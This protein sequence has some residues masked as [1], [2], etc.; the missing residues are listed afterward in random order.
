[1]DDVLGFAG[2]SAVVTGAASGMG[3]ATAQ[4]LLD[5]GANVTALDIKPTDVAVARS[6]EVDLRDPAAIESAAA[7]I[8]G[9]VDA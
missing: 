2:K 8:E 5:L 1:V 3:R 4:V 7:S 9:P 6:I